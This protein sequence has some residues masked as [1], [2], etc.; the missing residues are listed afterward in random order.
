MIVFDLIVGNERNID[1][2]LEKNREVSVQ[3]GRIPFK[4]Q[5]W[6]CI[7]AEIVGGKGL[8]GNMTLNTNQYLEIEMV[9]ES[10]T[11]TKCSKTVGEI[12]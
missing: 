3:A 2:D 10:M 4:M 12:V 1:C 7:I 8:C 11:N 6:T 5:M 9:K